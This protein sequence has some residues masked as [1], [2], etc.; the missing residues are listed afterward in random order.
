MLHLIKII[1]KHSLEA[2]T[3]LD[4]LNKDKDAWDNAIKKDTISAYESYIKEFSN[5]KYV[6]NAK[7]KIDELVKFANE[8]EKAWDK[9]QK[10]D[11]IDSYTR[12]KDKFSKG[13]Y[14]SEAKTR[15]EE[16]QKDK[17]AFEDAK[18]KNT[19]SAYDSYISRY[20]NGRYIELAK[21]KRD[22]LSSIKL[23]KLNKVFKREYN[24]IIEIINA[25]LLLVVI[26]MA[27]L[28]VMNIFPEI[29]QVVWMGMWL[30]SLLIIPN[31]ILC[32]IKLIV[33]IE[34]ITIFFRDKEKVIKFKDINN[35]KKLPK[36]GAFL[37]PLFTCPYFVKK[38]GKTLYVG[39][40][41]Y[42]TIN[43]YFK[44]YKESL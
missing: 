18:K 43:E 23:D 40:K 29:F 33:K 32:G 10:E 20:P 42:P 1:L 24:V 8:D 38:I 5:G 28:F 2:K 34:K 19:I 35:I 37:I 25:F 11:S 22:K 21:E 31:F 41:V 16:L 14:I 3:R 39:A 4:E 44:I 9:A 30:I 6:T 36:F 17:K 12:Y 26:V 13:K 27:P 15:L 7:K